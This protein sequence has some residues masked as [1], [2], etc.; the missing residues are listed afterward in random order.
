MWVEAQTGHP[1]LSAGR[2]ASLSSCRA[3]RRGDSVRSRRR[4]R[5][6]LR[7]SPNRSR[8]IANLL[9]AS[10]FATATPTDDALH[11]ELRSKLKT[12]RVGGDIMSRRN[13]FRVPSMRSRARWA[14]ASSIFLLLVRFASPAHAAFPCTTPLFGFGPIDPVHG[15]P[16]YYQDSTGLALQP[17]LDAVCGGVGFALPNPALP[18]SFPG[19][20]PVEVFYSRAIAKMTVGTISV[21]YTNA[22]EGSFVT[23]VAVPG[24]QVVFSRVRVRIFGV[25]P[26]STYT[27][28]HPYGVEVL[29][30]DALGTVNFTQ[31]SPRIPVGVGG[32]VLAFGTPITAGR[33]GP[34]LQAV[35]PAPP[36]GLVGNPAANQTVTGSPCA[37]NFVRIEGQG[38]PVGGQQTNL[39][40][41]IIGKIAHICDNGVLDL[42]EQCDDGNLVAGDC[43]SPTC[44]FE[45]A[46]QPCGVP[47]VCVNNACNGA[48][49]C[50][51]VNFTMAPCTDG[52]VC[53]L[54]DTCFSGAGVGAPHTCDD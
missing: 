38:F 5:K 36:P 22:L 46:G 50:A 7:E 21:V 18:L 34:F 54:A 11:Q 3:G 20:F 31:D 42:G 27:V 45:P 33:I 32:P 47:N 39:F 15:F 30:A 52:N 19:N 25:P 1:R 4:N 26:G 14:F 53:T 23:G 28:T 24:D 9:V 43:C 12:N 16:K 44:T 17:C 37:S 51:F 49:T 10:R 35:A 48:G 41:T 40:G 6:P 8:V 2:G 13:I 29:T